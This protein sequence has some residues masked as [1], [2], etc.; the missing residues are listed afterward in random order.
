MQRILSSFI[1]ISLRVS[2]M[3]ERSYYSLPDHS[4]MIQGSRVFCSQASYF[5]LR[6]S[7][8]LYSTMIKNAGNSAFLVSALVA[9]SINNKKKTETDVDRLMQESSFNN[10]SWSLFIYR[11][12]NNDIRTQTLILIVYVC[13]RLHCVCRKSNSQIN[14]VILAILQ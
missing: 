5:L 2:I 8:A 9:H 1:T 12:H 11:K 4:S 6:L 10:S 14:F 7:R 3:S 13:C